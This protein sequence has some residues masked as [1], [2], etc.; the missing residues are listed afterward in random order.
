MV[1]SENTTVKCALLA[2]RAQGG[3]DAIV[4]LLAELTMDEQLQLLHQTA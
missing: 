1:I 4:Q 3:P 2:A